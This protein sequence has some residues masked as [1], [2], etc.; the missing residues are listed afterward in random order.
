MAIAYAYSMATNIAYILVAIGSS[1]KRTIALPS[2]KSL[3]TVN[4]L[5]HPIFIPTIFIALM[6]DGLAR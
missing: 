1:P 4:P 6:F 2:I 3:F 5:F